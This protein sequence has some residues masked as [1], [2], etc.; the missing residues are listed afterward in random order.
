VKHRWLIV[1]LALVAASAFAVAAIAG[2]WWSISGSFDVEIG[3]YGSKRCFGSDCGPTDLSW[4]GGSERWMRTGMGTWAGCLLST[5][6]LVITAAAVA[7][8]RIPKLAAKTTLVSV[9]TAALAGTA[10]IAQYPRV[11]GSTIDRGIYLFAIAVICG[12]TT[13]IAVL[14]APRAEPPAE[15]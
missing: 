15:R 5:L 6:L 2:R 3:P 12:A 14:R 4:A 9:A 13:A 11:E 7:S 10:F 1:G 8:R